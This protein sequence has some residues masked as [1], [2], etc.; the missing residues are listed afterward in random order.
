METTFSLE[1]VKILLITLWSSG[2][3][4]LP[5]IAGIFKS[6]RTSMKTFWLIWGFFVI[7]TGG[8]LALSLTM[9]EVILNLGEKLL[10][11]IK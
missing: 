5:I 8:I 1:Q 7:I 4:I 3:I 11:L 9:P 10:S 6:A 2:V